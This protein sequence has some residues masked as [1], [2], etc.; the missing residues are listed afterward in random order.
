MPAA[1]QPKYGITGGEEAHQREEPVWPVS[2]GD[3]RFTKSHTGFQIQPDVEGNSAP[4]ETEIP[5][6]EL[7][8]PS[9][10]F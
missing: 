3:E 1:Q 7:V 8:V 4:T 10:A 2:G 6:G 9:P 5:G